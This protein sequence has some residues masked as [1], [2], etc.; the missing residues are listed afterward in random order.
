MGAAV[1]RGGQWALL[2]GS[3]DVSSAHLALSLHAAAND[4]T[5]LGERRATISLRNVAASKG[6][7]EVKNM[8]AGAAASRVCWE[9]GAYRVPIPPKPEFPLIC[10]QKSLRHKLGPRASPIVLRSTGA[11]GIQSRVFAQPTFGGAA[12]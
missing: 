3:V 5:G 7:E 8:C 9:P 6:E 4:C 12:T 2:R 10:G 1:G 11:S